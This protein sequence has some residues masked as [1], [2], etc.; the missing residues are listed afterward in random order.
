MLPDNA[1]KSGN[2]KGKPYKKY[3]KIL[4]IESFLQELI[5]IK[6]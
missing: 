1:M 3:A 4:N 5:S 6:K 2:L